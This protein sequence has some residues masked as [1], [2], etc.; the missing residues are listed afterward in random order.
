LKS[1]SVKYL[2]LFLFVTVGFIAT[3]ETFAQDLEPRF[4][5]NM[6][7]KANVALV[8][9]AY[10]SGNIMLD[11]T[12]PIE[13]LNSQL[14]SLVVAY[15]RS[16]KLLNKPAK[17]DAIVPASIASFTG[18]VDD[19]GAST[20]R[21]GL[22]DPTFRVSMLLI[23]AKPATL[24]EFAK[25]EHKKFKLGTLVRVRFPLG[26]Y[27]ETKLVNLGT[28][29][30]SFKTGL[31]SS[32]TFA[33]K[34]TLE[35]HI[36]TWAFTENKNFYNGNTIKQ[37]PLLT[38]QSHL[39]YQFKPGMWAAISI[40]GSTLGKTTV[41]GVE[42]DDSQKNSRTG[43]AFAYRLN[44]Q[45]SIKIAATTG[46]TTRYGSDFTTLLVAYQFLWFDKK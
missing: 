31:A 17:F 5:S 20:Q 2:A 39:T 7:T 16:F 36:N 43:I 29:R 11:N 14:N 6:P 25:L 21:N 10:S 18:T 26:Q 33:R 42:K 15:V 32:Y 8:S 44:N 45:N 1:V 23:G 37:K 13:D 24:S 9:Y 35:L 28:N 34:L 19:V 27:D 30:Y 3:E 46:V 4:L 38:M 22:G 12:L 41:N 40:G